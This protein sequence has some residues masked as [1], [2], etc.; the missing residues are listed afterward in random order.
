MLCVKPHSA[1]QGE[2]FDVTANSNH[3][4]GGIGMV[5]ALHRLFDDR[6]LIQVR[7][8]VMRC[9]SNQFDPA[10]VRLLIRSSAFEAGKERV[11]NVDDSP[12]QFC[13]ELV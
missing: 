12:G 8:Q 13:T 5:D 2:C 10:F 3:V 1:R 9:C 7:S 11:V 4:L 6:S